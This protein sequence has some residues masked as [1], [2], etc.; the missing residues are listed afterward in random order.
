M[1]LAEYFPLLFVPLHLHAVPRTL[2]QELVDAGKLEG[3][4]RQQQVLEAP[5]LAYPVSVKPTRTSS[6]L[7]F[8]LILILNLIRIGI[9]ILLS[10]PL[11]LIRI[12]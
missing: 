6:F 10:I 8:V 2:A 4:L 11:L 9:R 12:F 3:S 1:E 5:G 7:S